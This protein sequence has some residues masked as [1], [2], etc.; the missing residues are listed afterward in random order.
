M[1]YSSSPAIQENDAATLLNLSI[2]SRDSLMSTR[3][4]LDLLSHALS[5]P[6]SHAAVQS[7]AAALQSLLIA[8]ES[9]RSI[10]GSKHDILYSLL[11]IVG[12][13]HAPTRSIKDALKALFGTALYPLNRASLVGLGAVP[14]LV[15][16]IVRDA[17]TG[18]VEDATTEMSS[19]IRRVRENALAALLNM[20]RCGGER[21]RREVREMAV[22]AMEGIV[23]VDVMSSVRAKS[24][25]SALK[26]S[27]H[28][29]LGRPLLLASS[30]VI[31]ST[32]LTA[33]DS[34]HLR[35]CPNHC[36]LPSL[37]FSDT[38]TT[39]KDILIAKFGVMSHRVLPHAH[40]SI[41]ISS[42]SILLT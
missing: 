22:K 25:K 9:H 33:S 29:L 6:A 2:T 4:L 37:N 7:C 3:G 15:S 24:F 28:F 5:N 26:Q 19:A 21:G 1:L 8:D 11:S 18:I 32:L 41:L 39:P 30:T 31:D 16:L 12:D 14:A 34:C 20:A 42:G 27:T 23:E 17:R 38:V 40:R 36:S 35:T 13:K 10:I